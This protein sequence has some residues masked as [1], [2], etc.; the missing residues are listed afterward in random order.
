MNDQVHPIFGKL[1]AGMIEPKEF[2]EYDD[3]LMHDVMGNERLAKPVQALLIT[4][5]QIKLSHAS[6]GE[7]FTNNKLALESL[8]P[9]LQALRAAV[10]EQWQ[11]EQ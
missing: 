10:R 2:D 8:M 3:A 11:E 7:E 4:Y 6:F 5:R 9:L 1:L